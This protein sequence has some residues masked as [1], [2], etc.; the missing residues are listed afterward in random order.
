MD[1]LT[2]EQFDGLRSFVDA[3]NRGKDG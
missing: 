1:L 3:M 2:V